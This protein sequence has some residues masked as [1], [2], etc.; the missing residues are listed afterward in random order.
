MSSKAI[1]LAA[2]L[3]GDLQTRPG[4]R[5]LVFTDSFDVSGMPCLTISTDSTPAFGEKVMVLRVKPIDQSLAKDC[6]GLASKVHTPHVIQICTEADFE[7]TT[8]NVLD[9]LG[10]VELLSLIGTVCIRGTKVEWYRTANGTVPSVAAMIASNL[11]QS[12]DTSTWWNTLS[13]S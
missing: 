3:K 7:G 4:L 13:S 6:L 5:T 12:F 1:E 11:I 9:I 10:P 8:D 2:D